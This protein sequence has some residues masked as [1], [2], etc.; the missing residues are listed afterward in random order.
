MANAVFC[1]CLDTAEEMTHKLEDGSDASL[2]T[3]RSR[4]D[5]DRTWRQD[6]PLESVE[7]PRELWSVQNT[8]IT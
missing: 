4:R 5:R 6:W 2:G 8:H 1:V 7:G 3:E